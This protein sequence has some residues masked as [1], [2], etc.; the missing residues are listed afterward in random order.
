MMLRTCFVAMTVCVAVF[1]PFFGLLMELVG[2][3]C[4]TTMVFLLPVIFSWKLWGH[5][6]SLAQKVFGLFIVAVGA[7]GGSIGTAQAL[8]DIA[9]SLRAGKHE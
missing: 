3:L 4:L 1:V 9:A 7:I 8:N 5:D 6:M 2:A